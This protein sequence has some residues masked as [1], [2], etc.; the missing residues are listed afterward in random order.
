[1]SHTPKLPLSSIERDGGDGIDIHAADGP[2]VCSVPR[3]TLT[4]HYAYHAALIVAA[5][6]Q[7]AALLAERDRLR[8]ACRAVIANYDAACDEEYDEECWDAFDG[9]EPLRAALGEAK[10]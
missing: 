9:V 8:E 3:T 6:N 1:M 2:L 5:C 10:P 4:P 7:H